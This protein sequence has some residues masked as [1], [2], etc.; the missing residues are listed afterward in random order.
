ML[1]LARKVGKQTAHR[2]IGEAAA[3]GRREGLALKDAILRDQDITAHLPPDEIERIFDYS[4]QLGQC[5]ALV[6]RV[7]ESER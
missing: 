3:K 5:A 6:D 2:R 7:L 1:A 4:T